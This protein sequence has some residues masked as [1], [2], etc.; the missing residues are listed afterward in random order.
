M[1][2]VRWRREVVPRWYTSSPWC[3]WFN[4]DSIAAVPVE[5]GA[6]VQGDEPAFSDLRGA[7]VPRIHLS[8]SLKAL[9]TENEAQSL[10]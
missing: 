9:W 1:V 3:S 4:V 7:Q 6:G 2:G 10:G 8:E 5:K